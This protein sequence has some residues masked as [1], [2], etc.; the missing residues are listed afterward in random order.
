MRILITTLHFHPL[1]PVAAALEA[2][3]HEVAFACSEDNRPAM[4]TTGYRFFPAGTSM[5]ELMPSLMPRLMALPEEQ[6]EGWVMATTF[7]GTLPERI[8]PDLLAIC[9]DWRPDLLVRDA[10]EFGGCLV[11]EHL[12]L[13][14]A[15]V[16]VGSFL[17]APLVAQFAGTTLRRLRADLGL[18]PDPGLAMLH[19]YLHL[20]FVP[21]SYQDPAVPRP[22]TAHALR[23][24][25]FDRSGSELL[26]AWVADLPAWPV[27]YATL[28]LGFNRA[29]DLFAAIL[30]GLR[31]EPLT[32]IVTTGRNQDPAQFGPQP[33]NVYVERYIPQSLLFPRCD[34]VV[35]HGGWNT[36]LAALSA[37]LPLVLLPLGAD[38][39]HNAARCAA[40]R[41]GRVVGPGERT[42]DAIRDAVR[43][44]LADPT[45]RANAA[46]VR[47]EMAALPGPE[48]AVALLE[49][50]AR[51]QR[52][53]PTA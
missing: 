13:P 14:H 51:E 8:L 32:L 38:Q 21:P 36:V 40:L 49:Q 41:V 25:V 3:G 27:V 29:T 43:A 24:I 34:L 17:P 5:A 26:P 11:A 46:R 7:G 28:G 16:E 15:S 6:Q 35:C 30:A 52:P 48:H 31:E 45:Y 12:G 19:R 47:D 23:T 18:A 10:I 44:V 2:A 37:G 22:P 42:P 1:A 4:E 9:H 39:P 53:I 50:L 20:A 33:P